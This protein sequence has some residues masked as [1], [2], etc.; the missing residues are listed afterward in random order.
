M[1]T[2]F[3]VGVENTAPPSD[4]TWKWVVWSVF[5]LGM[6]AN[7]ATMTALSV[8]VKSPLTCLALLGGA[9]VLLLIAAALVRW[10]S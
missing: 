5:I 9:F 8:A 10:C 1:N 7:V 4:S 6:L 2:S 3:T